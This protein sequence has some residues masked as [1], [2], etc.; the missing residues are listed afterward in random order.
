MSIIY[1]SSNQKNREE[2][3][4]YLKDKGIVTAVYY[5]VPLHLQKAYRDLG[6]KEGGDLPNA[7]YL[8]HRTFAIPIFPELTDNEKNI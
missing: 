6:Y 4:N 7:E 2:I 5:P 3:I 8:S 1:I